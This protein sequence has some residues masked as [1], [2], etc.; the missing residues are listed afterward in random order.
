MSILGNLF[1]SMVGVDKDL[2]DDAVLIDVRNPGEFASG[3]IEGAISLPL[4]RIDQG[5]EFRVPDKNTPIIVY[6]VSGARSAAARNGLIKLGYT[7]VSNGG[8]IGSLA[9]KLHKMICRG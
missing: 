3:Y 1:G 9:I 2:P 4:D 5:I 8:G 7:N 6:C